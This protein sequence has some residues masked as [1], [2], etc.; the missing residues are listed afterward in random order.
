LRGYTP[1]Q[2]RDRASWA[3]QGE[4]RRTVRGRLG[5]VAFAGLGGVS[6]KIS[7]IGESTLLPGGGAGLRFLVAPDYRI[8][9]RLD[10]AV[11]RDSHAVYVS[12][13]EAF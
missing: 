11:G 1:G 9:L 4:W 12:I 6:P 2:F 10:A 5:V 8:N 7:S 3:V 13:G